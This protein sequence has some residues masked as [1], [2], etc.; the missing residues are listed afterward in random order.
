MDLCRCAEDVGGEVSVFDSLEEA[1]RGADV[2]VTVTNASEPLVFGKWVKPGA[3]VC[4]KLLMRYLDL[5]NRHKCDQQ[6]SF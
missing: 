1:V 5:L 3:V 2:V 6:A 4:C